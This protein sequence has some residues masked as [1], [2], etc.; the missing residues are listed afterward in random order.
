MYIYIYCA[1]TYV[2]TCFIISGI[3]FPADNYSQFPSA[4]KL[5]FCQHFNFR[6]CINAARVV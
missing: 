3:A 2:C 1:T 5:N 6:K 4:Y